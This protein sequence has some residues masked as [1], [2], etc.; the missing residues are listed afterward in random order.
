MNV[1]AYEAPEYSLRPQIANIHDTIELCL[2]CHQEGTE[3][4]Q[5]CLQHGGDHA[6]P[7]HLKVMQSCIEIS[8]V[9]ARFMMLQS[10]YQHMMCEI[11]SQI[12][13]ACA[14]ACEELHDD[15]LVDHI[16]VALQC[17]DACRR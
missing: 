13:L 9:C 4:F 14:K 10:P 2:R 6:D 17:A 12:C 5:Y 3:A 7:H 1:H 11:C 15:A 16:H 8:Y